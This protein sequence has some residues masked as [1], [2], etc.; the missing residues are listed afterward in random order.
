MR[1]PFPLEHVLYERQLMSRIVYVNTGEGVL[2]ITFSVTS[3][4]ECF[5]LQLGLHIYI[6]I[7]VSV[8]GHSGEVTFS[9]AT[10][11]VG[12]IFCHQ[13]IG[14]VNRLPESTL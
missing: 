10:F 2:L 5:Y 4:D 11:I 1:I 13:S 6:Y 8:G 12:F 3:F 7:I 14:H 9:I